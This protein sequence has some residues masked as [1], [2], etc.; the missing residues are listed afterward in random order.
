[1]TLPFPF[2]KGKALEDKK[3]EEK[4]L[5]A[6]SRKHK[7]KTPKLPEDPDFKSEPI[8]ETES[9]SRCTRRTTQENGQKAHAL[10]EPPQKKECMDGREK[11][12]ETKTPVKDEGN[13]F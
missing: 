4:P 5:K 10:N 13:N 12:S 9:L 1:M 6:Y 8:I 2:V 3:M 7:R 11:N